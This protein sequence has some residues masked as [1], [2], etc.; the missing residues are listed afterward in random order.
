MGI[1]K[2]RVMSLN[3]IRSICRLFML[4]VSPGYIMDTS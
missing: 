1:D 4:A 2:Y 3:G